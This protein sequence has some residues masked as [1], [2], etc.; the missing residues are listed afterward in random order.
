MIKAPTTNNNK[1]IEINSIFR[2]NKSKITQKKIIK[3]FKTKEIILVKK[4]KMKIA[5]DIKVA[6]IHIKTI[7]TLKRNKRNSWTTSTG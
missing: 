5:L 7:Y 4:G 1:R 3:V 2:A 6:S